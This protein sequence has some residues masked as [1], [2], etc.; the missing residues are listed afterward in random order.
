[1]GL[2]SWLISRI[3]VAIIVNR[4]LMFPRELYIERITPFMNRPLVKVIAGIRRC[5][6]SVVLQLIARALEGRGVRRE[7]IVYM[8]F[9]SFEWLDVSDAKALYKEVKKRV[10]RIDGR[11][12]ILLDE[13]QEVKDWERAVNSFMVDWDVDVYVTGSNS[14]MLS[15]ELS[16]Y[17]T[18][19]YISF[20]ILPLSFEEYFVFHG[21]SV[22]GD[23]HELYA[24]FERYLRMGGFPAAHVG[25]YQDEDIYKMV[26]DIYSSVILRDTVERHNIRNVELLERVTKFVFDNI[27]NRLNA[28]NISDYFKSQQRRVDPNTI[29][30]YLDALQSAF[31]IQR[32]P[33]YDIKG[34]EQLQTNEKYFVGDL[35]LVYAVMGYKDR[36]ISGALENV[37]YWEMRRRGYEVFIGKQ[38]DKEVDF[39]G[40]LR[41]RK[42]YVQVT[43]RLESETTIQREFG[44]LLSIED[45]YPKYVVSMDEV[46]KGNIEGVKH[47]HVAEFL[48]DK[49]W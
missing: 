14:R 37:V 15:S 18:G 42:M 48:V 11:A 27:G 12:Y 44:P 28:K 31:I 20:Q 8:N 45:H 6:K 2:K 33:R 24:H 47:V 16:T 29:Y 22:P 35:S 49:S 21:I 7:Q 25:D 17:L 23:R 5:G 39:V 26:F 36:A 13:I 43:Y 1:M 9:E 30:N 46:W 19:R 10:E 38:E 32:V 40:V 4:V 3:F 41:D 34:K